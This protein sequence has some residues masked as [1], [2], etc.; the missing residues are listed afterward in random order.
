V[1]VYRAAPSGSFTFDATYR[2][3][4]T[5][6]TDVDSDGIQEPLI[7]FNIAGCRLTDLD[8]DG[9]DDVVIINSVQKSKPTLIFDRQTCPAQKCREWIQNCISEHDNL[10]LDFCTFEVPDI[11][12]S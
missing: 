6:W 1:H 2:T 10:G 3:T 9:D 8:A 4:S 11:V 12:D 5:A 7:S